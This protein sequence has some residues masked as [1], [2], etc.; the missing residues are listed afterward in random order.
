[1]SNI[2]KTLGD[3]A[4]HFGTLGLEEA[5][6]AIGELANDAREPWKKTVLGLVAD[7]IE[8]H[9]P[10]G[11]EMARK[12]VERAMKGKEADL[13]WASLRHRSDLL[14]QLQ[15]AE[16]KRRSEVRI[17]LEKIGKVLGVILAA[18]VKAIVS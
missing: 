6:N 5:S 1:M 17:F 14:A 3:L 9:G 4:E 10:E 12:A 2:L 7:A 18:M 16:A 13:S 15:N 11:L 8:E